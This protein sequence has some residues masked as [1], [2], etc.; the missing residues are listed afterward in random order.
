MRDDGHPNHRETSSAAAMQRV[1]YSALHRGK[2]RREYGG[3]GD[4][5]SI[6]GSANRASTGSTGARELIR[7][8]RRLTETSVWR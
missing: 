8:T 6:W 1:G 2:P 5:D 7:G 3:R 4:N